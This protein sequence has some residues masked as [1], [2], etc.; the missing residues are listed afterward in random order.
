MARSL[1]LRALIAALA[2]FAIVPASASALPGARVSSSKLVKHVDYPGTQ[3]L[4]YEYGPIEIL[5][6]QNNIEAELNRNKPTVP[7]YITRFEPEPRLLG[8]RKIPRVDVIHL[9]HGVWLNN[10]YPTFAAGEEKTTQ[11]LPRGYGYH[12]QPERQL[13][14][15]LHDP[16]PHAD[17]RRRCRSPT[18][19]TSCPT[20]R[21]PRREASPRPSRSGWTSRASAPTRS[22]TR[23]RARARSGKFTFPDQASA[24]QQ[25][26]IG[27]AH[28][29]RG[30]AAT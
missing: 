2:A 9:H 4:H 30:P 28:A 20:A 12:Y 10:G 27:S 24:S 5:P 13:D 6:G 25:D 23:S 17:G 8:Q 3:H 18:T 16:Q 19:S 14:H 15:E 21:P 11:Q 1:P 22:S 7:G 26:D 29:V